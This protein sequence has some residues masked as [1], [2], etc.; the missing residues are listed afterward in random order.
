MVTVSPSCRTADSTRDTVDE[1]P[2][3]AAVVADL[4]ARA[5]V[6]QRRVVARRQHVGDDDVVVGVAADLDRA[7]RGASAGRPGRRIFS[8]LVARLPSLE[9][10]AAVGPIAVTDSRAGCDSAGWA[11]L[12]RHRAG[13]T[14][15]LRL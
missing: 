14:G 6:H 2:V 1:G 10:G 11:A 3:D 4:G 5:P 8:M 12:L 15:W 9:R 7:R 13:R